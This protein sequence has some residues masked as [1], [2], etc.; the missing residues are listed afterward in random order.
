MVEKYFEE[1]YTQRYTASDI[2]AKEL[3]A[4]VGAA[5]STLQA[6]HLRISASAGVEVVHI[7]QRIV[8]AVDIDLPQGM[9]VYAPRVQGYI[10]I[11][12]AITES[13]A[14]ATHPAVYPPSKKLHLKAINETVPVYTGQVRVLR[15]VTIGKNV[16]PGELTVEGTFRYQACDDKECFNPGNG[17]AEVGTACRGARS[18]AS[19]VRDSTQVG[20]TVGRAVATHPLFRS[21]S[22]AWQ[23]VF[24]T[25]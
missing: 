12:L 20:T 10:P 3:G 21:G 18:S 6:K 5:H 2:L 1:D 23:S 9:H 24:A 19:P 7:G 11:D 17:A 14:L 16:K 4:A 15:E 22:D 13:N 25:T 8:L